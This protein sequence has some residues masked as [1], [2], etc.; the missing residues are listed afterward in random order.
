MRVRFLGFRLLKGVVER[1]GGKEIQKWYFFLPRKKYHPDALCSL[2]S[3]V[4]LGALQ[5]N[6]R[7]H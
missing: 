7:G 4:F 1:G 2:T 3:R 6:C 5:E